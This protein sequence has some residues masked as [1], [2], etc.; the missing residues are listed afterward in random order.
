MSPAGAASTGMGWF[1][2]YAIDLD[3][4][5]RLNMAFAESSASPLAGGQ[6]VTKGADL[7]WEP[8]TGE[9]IRTSRR[10]PTVEEKFSGR[11]FIYVSDQV[12]DE[13]REMERRQDSIAALTSP[14][15]ARTSYQKLYNQFMYVGYPQLVRG[16]QFLQSE[17]R[18]RIRVNRAFT[19]YSETPTNPDGPNQNPQY[20]FTLQGQSVVTNQR[21]VACKALE[22]VRVVPN[23]Y[24]AYSTYEEGQ[25]ATFSRITNL[26]KRAQITIYTLNGT[27]VRRINK[28]DVATWTDF[29]MRNDSGLPIS[30]GI[31]L[32]HV[33]DPATGCEEIVKWFCV[34]RPVDL[35]SFGN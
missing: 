34:M 10:L 29:N 30:S 8:G 31:Y 32:F 35:D 21:D 3:R 16:Q 27:L 18:V 17:A 6:D 20:T 11:N 5:V 1:P 28:D 2:G 19:S 23:P 24:Y 9:P 22:L 7:I 26:P 13:G 33:K 15:L 12:Y 25:I 4:G 14:P